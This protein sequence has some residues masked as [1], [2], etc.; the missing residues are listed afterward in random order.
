MFPATCSIQ[1]SIIAHERKEQRVNHE[2]LGNQQHQ[3]RDT[4]VEVSCL[5]NPDMS[6]LQAL[7]DHKFRSSWMGYPNVSNDLT[8]IQIQTWL[9]LKIWYT[10]NCHFNIVHE[11]FLTTN[12]IGCRATRIFRQNKT[13][14]L[15]V[16]D[17]PTWKNWMEWITGRSFFHH[18]QKISNV[19]Q[20]CQVRSDNNK[21]LN[22]LTP[23]QMMMM[24]IHEIL[25][26]LSSDIRRDPLRHQLK[27]P[28]RHGAS[29]PAWK[30]GRPTT[31]RC[32]G[33]N[34]IMAV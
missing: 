12:L 17:P 29:E 23:K 28:S 31:H 26:A 14:V 19:N 15:S 9:C 32:A 30:L 11:F 5:L 4:V 34:Q 20:S 16:T 22:R 7:G 25:G 6:R 10:H 18:S 2:I 13:I 27:S 33:C 21:Y 1:L 8:H 24:M 3:E